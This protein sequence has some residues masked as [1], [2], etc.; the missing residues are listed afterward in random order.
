MEFFKQ[1]VNT[2]SSM[3][4]PDGFNLCEEEGV[5]VFSPTAAALSNFETFLEKAEEVAGRRRG[6]VKVILPREW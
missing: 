4:V 3:V 5:Y 1:P 6:V 2:D